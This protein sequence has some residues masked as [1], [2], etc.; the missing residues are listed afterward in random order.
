MNQFRGVTLIISVLI[1][2]VGIVTGQSR[3]RVKPKTAPRVVATPITPAP[4]R[5]PIRRMV[6]INLKQGEPV[7]GAFLQADA[8]VVQIEA[9]S[10]RLTIKLNEID[11]LVFAANELAAS[12]P[13]ASAPQQNPT[14]AAP[15]DPTLPAARK[16]YQALR[17]LADAVQLGLPYPQFGNLLIEV[18]PTVEE[19]L[20]ALPETALKADLKE[21]LAAYVEGG[22]AWA[23]MQVTGALPIATEPGATL[24]KKY[25]IKP[26][27]NALGAADHLRLDVT[28]SVI[29]ATAAKRLDNAAPMLKP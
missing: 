1:L 3:S 6:T 23:A 21:A 2:V 14:A 17:K 22:Q 10:G 20:A 25:E 19:A 7:T 26:S 15:P 13:A 8:E 5:H 11:S 29:W 28:L 18:K 27:V 24:M 9:Q 16:A 12:K 4:I